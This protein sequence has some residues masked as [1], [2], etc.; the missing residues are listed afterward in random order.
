MTEPVARALAA[1]GVAGL[2]AAFAPGLRRRW[3]VLG[4][5]A[6]AGAVIG[7]V[8]L[9]RAVGQEPSEVQQLLNG[10]FLGSI[11]ALIALGYT[12]VYGVLKLINFAHGEVFMVGCYVGFFGLTIYQHSPLLALP[13][14]LAVA[15]FLCAALG[16]MIERGA[17]RPLR[18][19][20]RLA[21]LITAIGV[22]LLL[23]NLALLLVG[24]SPKTVPMVMGTAP[25]VAVQQATGLLVNKPGLT[26]AAAAVALMLALQ[27]FVSRTRTGRAMRAV[28]E[29]REAAQLMGIDIDRIIAVTFV[30]GSALAGAGGVLWTLRY[31]SVTPDV[32]VLPGLKAF[33][34]AVLGGIGSISGAMLGGLLIGLTEVLISTISASPQGL[35][36]CLVTLLMLVAF[37]RLAAERLAELPHTRSGRVLQGAGLLGVAAACWVTAGVTASVIAP[38]LSREPTVA[39]LSGSTFRD[40][41]VFA[42]LIVILIVKPTGLMGRWAPE[43]V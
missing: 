14:T 31:P 18:Q 10:L 11:Y 21:A 36:Q 33:V 28:S 12:M 7:L 6:S 4:A 40:A 20:P 43:K 15:M 42:I 39:A 30:I 24:A 35:V 25:L 1:L 22:S 37:Y 3:R 32:G 13:V 41:V 29:D 9:R 2:G 27:F 23:Q 19:A 5:L 38:L 16:V 17:Y 8:V 26:S 34:A